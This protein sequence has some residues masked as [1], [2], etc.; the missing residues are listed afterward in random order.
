[1]Y[2]RIIQYGNG[3][4]DADEQPP[5][6]LRTTDEMLNEFSYLDSDLAEEIVITNPAKI[7]DMIEDISPIHPDKCPP[8][9]DNSEEELRNSCHARA[10][11]IYGDPVPKVVHD[12]LEK[13]LD[14]IIGNGYAVMYIMARRLVLKSN[15]DGYLVGSR[16]SVGSSFAAT[17]SGI[18]EVNPLKPHY[19][20][21][22]CQYSEF[23]SEEI[24]SLNGG[25]GWDLPDK[26]CPRCG[27]PLHKDGIDTPFETFLGFNGDKEPD[28]DLNFS[29]EY[30]ANA[31]AYTEVMFGKG[32]T[33]RAGTIT[34]VADKNSVW[35]CKE[36]F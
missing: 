29:G 24:R 25:V 11:E 13:E 7:S 26:K 35:L 20:C 18:T 28:I 5:L 27:A 4:K 14:S 32:H 8:V 16:G 36:L 23:D 12:R 33:F 15:E 6:Y 21:L 30:Q 31:H 9:L 19:Y 1:M 2:R 17:M 34:G 3:F 10:K 22:N